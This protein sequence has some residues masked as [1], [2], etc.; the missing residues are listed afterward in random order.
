MS[1]QI[2]RRVVEA[3]QQPARV[4]E[5]AADLT[6]REFEILNHLAQG[7]LYKEIAETL[8]QARYRAHSCPPHL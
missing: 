1:N 3:F 5:P 8:D 4:P 2:A 7:K 6:E